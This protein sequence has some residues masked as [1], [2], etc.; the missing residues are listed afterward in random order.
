MVSLRGHPESPVNRGR[1]CAKGHAGLFKPIHPERL[2]YPLVRAGARGENRWRRVSWEEA[3]RTVARGL[4]E[5][6]ADRALQ[7]RARASAERQIGALLATLGFTAVHF[8]D[9][10]PA[11]PAS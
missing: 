3:L 7:G 11:V 8:V 2:L 6:S 9:A 1:L 5:V 10:L 4:R